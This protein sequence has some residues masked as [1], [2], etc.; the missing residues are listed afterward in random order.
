MRRLD[1]IPSVIIAACCLHNFI[2][3]VDGLD[4]EDFDDINDEEENDIVHDDCELLVGQVKINR[5]AS[6]LWKSVCYVDKQ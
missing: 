3:D 4:N 6:M 1:F 2:L 5:I